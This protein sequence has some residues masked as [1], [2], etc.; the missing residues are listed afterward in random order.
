M[1]IR[2]GPLFSN[3]TKFEGSV[4]ELAAQINRGKKFNFRLLL[5]LGAGSFDPSRILLFFVGSYNHTACHNH[6][7]ECLIT[8]LLDLGADPNSNGYR[9]TPL[10]I[11][12]GNKT[13]KE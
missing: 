8:K 1:M 12:V 7:E 5:E 9:V 11:A 3:C 4:I 10:Q 2:Y 13:L 6:V